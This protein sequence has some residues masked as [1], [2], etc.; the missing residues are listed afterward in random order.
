MVVELT[1]DVVRRNGTL[2]YCIR[3]KDTLLNYLNRMTLFVR[4]S[5]VVE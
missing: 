5:L 2:L 4:G 3:K 1:D